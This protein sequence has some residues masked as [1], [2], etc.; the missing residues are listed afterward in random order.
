MVYSSEKTPQH[1]KSDEI[2]LL[3][4][5][6]PILPPLPPL[7][8]RWMGFSLWILSKQL[9]SGVIADLDA[10]GNIFQF[11]DFG[12]SVQ[13]SGDG[14]L[15]GQ[16]MNLDVP[17]G[18]GR[19]DLSTHWAGTPSEAQQ[20]FPQASGVL[21]EFV[22][23]RS[24]V[25]SEENFA[26]DLGVSWNTEP[27]PS[28]S[29]ISDSLLAGESQTIESPT[30]PKAKLPQANPAASENPTFEKDLTSDNFAISGQE[31]LSS[32]SASKT[33][34]LNDS[35]EFQASHGQLSESSELIQQNES[36]PAL[37]Q[38]DRPSNAD[39]QNAQGLDDHL[40]QAE[41]LVS[42]GFSADELSLTHTETP[43]VNIAEFSD[44]LVPNLLE[45]QQS[46]FR[47]ETD[48]PIEGAA[49]LD[50]S[51]TLSSPVDENTGLSLSALNIERAE[52][53]SEHLEAVVSQDSQ[54]N[55]AAQS[56]VSRLRID[57]E[58]EI[59]VPRSAEYLPENER[60]EGIE[61]EHSISDAA[62]SIEAEQPES[63][64][65]EPQ[66]LPFLPTLDRSFPEIQAATLAQGNLQ[67]ES[68]DPSDSDRSVFDSR[69]SETQEGLESLDSSSLLDEQRSNQS[70]D[71]QT[72]GDFLRDN[73]ALSNQVEN[74]ADQV[75]PD[76]LDFPSMP[77]QAPSE[78]PA[79]DFEVVPPADIDAVRPSSSPPSSNDFTGRDGLA[80]SDESSALKTS[81][82]TQSFDSSVDPES[83]LV[84]NLPQIEQKDL[85]STQ[86]VP[87]PVEPEG[88]LLNWLNRGVNWVKSKLEGTEPEQDLAP[89]KDAPQTAPQVEVG[90]DA[91]EGAKITP[92][93]IRNSVEE[94]TIDPSLT[95]SE[96]EKDT[97][98]ISEASESVFAADTSLSYPEERSQ[99]FL[100]PPE[101]IFNRFTTEEASDEQPSQDSEMLSS[102][103]LGLRIS[104]TIAT[105]NGSEALQTQSSTTQHSNIDVEFPN[106]SN[107]PEST[108][109]GLSRSGEQRLETL[110]EAPLPSQEDVEGLGQ[111]ISVDSDHSVSMGLEQS[112]QDALAFSET[113][114]TDSLTLTLG[115]PPSG[116]AEQANINALNT[117]QD[118]QIERSIQ[119]EAVTPEDVESSITQHGKVEGIPLEALL[120]LEPVSAQGHIETTIDNTTSSATGSQ[121]FQNGL[122]RESETERD[123]YTHEIPA[124]AKDFQPLNEPE[125]M[126][127]GQGAR[128]E[129]SEGSTSFRSENA[130]QL[131]LVE[132]QSEHS[133]SAER[134]SGSTDLSAEEHISD[135]LQD[136]GDGV[137]PIFE[138]D[139]AVPLFSALTEE[140][141]LHD[142]ER[143]ETIRN[144]P[145]TTETSTLA[146]EGEVQPD[147][148][149]AP[150][151][152][153]EAAESILSEALSTKDSD[154]EEVVADNLRVEDSET[155]VQGADLD[156]RTQSFEGD[157]DRA[158]EGQASAISRT[159]NHP[160]AESLFN[161]DLST[162]VSAWT[163]IETE[164]S[165]STDSLISSEITAPGIEEER[166][167][168]QSISDESSPNPTTRQPSTLDPSELAQHELIQSAEPESVSPQNAQAESIQRE[169][170]RT[171]V[172]ALPQEMPLDDAVLS[173]IAH[174][175]ISSEPSLQPSTEQSAIAA[176]TAQPKSS[177][178]THQREPNPARNEVS[179][180]PERFKNSVVSEFSSDLPSDERSTLND[181]PVTPVETV[182][183]IQD[184][185]LSSTNQEGDRRA[186]H[187][188]GTFN[189]V[190]VEESSSTLEADRMPIQSIP[191]L[192][193]SSLS[194]DAKEVEISA[195]L[196]E[197]A[198][199]STPDSAL[200]TPVLQQDS[201]EAVPEIV[202]D[203]SQPSQTSS[204][205]ADLSSASTNALSLSEESQQQPA[206]TDSLINSNPNPFSLEERTI[207]QAIPD[208]SSPN[209]VTEETF[210]SAINS[211][212]P[213]Q[214]DQLQV[215]LQTAASTQGEQPDPIESEVRETNVEAFS[216]D[217]D[218]STIFPETVDERVSSETSLQPLNEQRA[219][220]AANTESNFFLEQNETHPTTNEVSETP[221]NS[222]TA[223]SSSISIFLDSL[224]ERS[225][226]NDASAIPVDVGTFLQEAPLS[227]TINQSVEHGSER[228]DGTSNAVQGKQNAS[229]I[230]EPVHP[231]NSNN[232]V[233]DSAPL[234]LDEEADANAVVE[235]T[236]A[237][238]DE[239][240]NLSNQSETSAQVPLLE[241]EQSVSEDISGIEFKPSEIEPETI[242]QP[243]ADENHP[244]VESS[245]IALTLT[246]Q[247]SQSFFDS[248][249]SP[250][251]NIPSSDGIDSPKTVQDERA[252]RPE[253]VQISTQ[254]QEN[255]TE[256]ILIENKS[257]TGKDTPKAIQLEANSALSD[258]PTTTVS[259]SETLPQS[260][261]QNEQNAIAF[262]LAPN[263]AAQQ[264]EPPTAS[265]DLPE[266]PNN[267]EEALNSKSFNTE[268]N[269][270]A[271]NE[272]INS[273][274]QDPG[275]FIL[276]ESSSS[277]GRVTPLHDEPSFTA[278]QDLPNNLEPA[279]FILDEP[280]PPEKQTS[281]QNLNTE[282]E[283]RNERPG[284]DF[285]FGLS[286]G[287]ESLESESAPQP[288]RL[289]QDI[290]DQNPIPL[291]FESLQSSSSRGAESPPP[292]RNEVQ[293]SSLESS[294][295][296]PESLTDAS[297]TELSHPPQSE[298]LE[299][300]VGSSIGNISA[301]QESDPPSSRAD[302]DPTVSV[303]P[304]VD[305][306]RSVFATPQGFEV[307]QSEIEA[308]TQ[309]QTAINALSPT[310][311]LGSPDR[312][313]TQQSH[314]RPSLEGIQVELLSEGMQSHPDETSSVS[315]QNEIL[316]SS[317][318]IQPSI[319]LEQ[320]GLPQGMANSS[321]TQLES[322]FGPSA[323]TDEIKS[324]PTHQ[325]VNANPNTDRSS[326][327]SSNDEIV[328]SSVSLEV[329]AHPTDN[330]SDT[331][332]AQIP[333]E[334]V[335]F[336]QD[337]PLPMNWG[338]EQNTARENA[339]S[340]ISQ[341]EPSA[342]ASKEEVQDAKNPSAS[343]SDSKPVPSDVMGTEIAQATESLEGFTPDLA[344]ESPLTLQ[345]RS[346]AITADPTQ[347]PETQTNTAVDSSNLFSVDPPNSGEE[348]QPSS[349]H[350]SSSSNPILDRLEE[351]TILQAIPDTSSPEPATQESSYPAIDASQSVQHDWPNA[352]PESVSTQ[353]EQTELIQRGS[354]RNAED[355]SQPGS[356][357]I[358]SET[359]RERISA[360]PSL[361]PTEQS[362]IAANT[363]PNLY[364]QENERYSTTDISSETLDKH[365][366]TESP[367]VIPLEPNSVNPLT[368][369]E[370]P[371]VTI[372]SPRSRNN[373][374]ENSGQNLFF[375]KIDDVSSDS[376]SEYL[377]S[378]EPSST[379]ER[380]TQENISSDWAIASSPLAQNS[381]L[382]SHLSLSDFLQQNTDDQISRHQSK[383][384]Y[385][386]KTSTIR[387]QQNDL[388]ENQIQNTA[389]SSEIETDLNNKSTSVRSQSNFM[390]G[391]SPIYWNNLEELVGSN[392][393][394]LNVI[395]LKS[396][397]EIQEKNKRIPDSWSNLKDL[398]DSSSKPFNSES[399]NNSSLHEN[400]FKEPHHGWNDLSSIIHSLES[401]DNN[402]I[403]AKL[404][405]IHT[406]TDDKAEEIKNNLFHLKE[407]LSKEPCYVLRRDQFI[408][409]VVNEIQSRG[410]YDLQT[411]LTEQALL[412]DMRGLVTSQSK[413]P[414][415]LDFSIIEDA[416]E[417]I[418]AEPKSENLNLIITDLVESMSRVS[419]RENK[420]FPFFQKNINLDM[421]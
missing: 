58:E 182:A 366:R 307:L 328:G 168:L 7:G 369:T 270:P 324:D 97:Q 81:P 55:S 134:P 138:G 219:I 419:R 261:F 47:E 80:L 72:A 288:N 8:S 20:P 153:A 84:E 124:P 170:S 395:N 179:E 234:H 73:N 250:S 301:S 194:S 99:I 380:V 31:I 117:E 350:F 209:F 251:P 64:I 317:E 54:E 382:L 372:E 351:R 294:S 346:E 60:S 111:Q 300:A 152:R 100:S 49:D 76:A 340:N 421:F 401:K 201:S 331:S 287:S 402:K 237:D 397:S 229:E 305:S 370:Q 315:T 155:L 357:E 140:E 329:D 95:A 330:I 212:A 358:F 381:G 90:T 24:D 334:A 356:N 173:E 325:L 407:N 178:S 83:S 119:T 363:N 263:Q 136:I 271:T 141:M 280:S 412:N 120:S 259:S 410:S 308:S 220:A 75:Q 275:T 159:P 51:A 128:I 183:F 186:N 156:E 86:P 242:I 364:A 262:D 37:Q 187:E 103:E 66:Q 323:I 321:E 306:E 121:Q 164:P 347:K 109:S 268:T 41:R 196:A 22:P 333:L 284:N 200:E 38:A 265:D 56:E 191:N 394:S 264:I 391:E 127:L 256:L 65:H 378:S 25:V 118:A 272:P 34:P 409:L 18:F 376:G 104:E 398:V 169:V 21:A 129:L 132:P 3:G 339:S 167:I 151:N 77:N 231:L 206:L 199:G 243:L 292:K 146:D 28:T 105:E 213:V 46:D 29:V 26:A 50:S 309:N 319:S 166:T 253:S 417:K 383:S 227:P 230:E 286:F 17:D 68:N 59:A 30:E 145:D 393:Q 360:S 314:N 342:P 244:T 375:D 210:D 218:R 11:W 106:P 374:I 269:E 289:N 332:S 88:G 240:Q 158:Q 4:A 266:A 87:N 181:T 135:Q 162:D 207:L 411:S 337:T 389:I 33:A 344:S 184:G 126:D 137:S 303:E 12:G 353:N 163:G 192:D 198:E 359:D 149:T 414:I 222:E 388:E 258:Q 281:S 203:P 94:K 297:N 241:T 361:P 208:E 61:R 6:Y 161:S 326:E 13:D 304:L 188:D 245:V 290:Q 27:A 114:R 78:V 276:N 36:D 255:Q 224:D 122:N 150:V 142:A 216:Q 205:V 313:P 74:L 165:V 371:S 348:P 98:P 110:S 399:R 185:A 144:R 404:I 172:E 349:P 70:F 405:K 365:E 139:N 226:H 327:I 285:D 277:A 112:S 197:R 157:S 322:Q 93:A 283:S 171:N 14:W 44:T 214:D 175:R 282:G 279:T 71:S 143:S 195:Q 384:V 2:P 23:E 248:S 413:C 274:A 232:L 273:V 48:P 19:S 247:T 92:K 235:D 312:Q 62:L 379:N 101:N 223:K 392:T 352:E 257:V 125:E 63:L 343:S 406:K 113:D 1:D 386:T 154:E 215:V 390:Y 373:P 45:A 96:F 238:V 298:F 131:S 10:F 9:K 408:Q 160:L 291:G 89:P 252:D 190:H 335:T 296:P 32:A 228:L 246:E 338:V 82:F 355:L 239:L 278:G 221:T 180:P 299:T 174:E 362:A 39:V 367:S 211:S 130:E 249:E 420:D 40:N 102:N 377:Q 254:G 260:S 67:A 116:I 53:S 320:E 193:R 387:P 204:I 52:L 236:D 415:S 403:S 416:Y 42:Q 354:G 225:A 5:L 35:L 233:S 385:G 43:R 345:N 133:A 400:Y 396:D 217:P 115:M 108:A 107:T 336:I 148:E 176:D 15:Y 85:P 16:L 69:E 302:F 295:H 189:T 418:C 316:D 123:S 177:L 310:F 57:A 311:G 267:N 341:I 202:L 318:N 293:L 147:P 368:S 79:A 91:V